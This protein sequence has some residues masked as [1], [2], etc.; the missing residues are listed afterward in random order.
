MTTFPIPLPRSKKVMPG[1]R[2]TTL[3]ISVM[4][5]PLDLDTVKFSCR[6]EC[7]PAV[8]FTISGR[9]ERL[10]PACN[11]LHARTSRPLVDFLID[12]FIHLRGNAAPSCRG[13]HE[14]VAIWMLLQSTNHTIDILDNFD[15]TRSIARFERIV[16]ALKEVAPERRL[17][18]G[19]AG[20]VP[21]RSL[22]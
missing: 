2:P 13:P 4:S 11:F 10:Q 17:T 8:E 12:M 21:P 6:G 16:H 5:L 15:E 7:A 22:G 9:G 20:R 19:S 18:R 3:T 1:L 14:L